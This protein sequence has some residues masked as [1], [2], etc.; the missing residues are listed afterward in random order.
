MTRFLSWKE[1]PTV[2]LTEKKQG[3]V[4]KVKLK[5]KMIMNIEFILINIIFETVSNIHKSLL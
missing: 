2:E 1:S 5:L 3:A 4:Y